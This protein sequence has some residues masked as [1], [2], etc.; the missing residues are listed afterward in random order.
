V[1]LIVC[2][3]PKIDIAIPRYEIPIARSPKERTLIQPIDYTV[4][5]EDFV[6]FAEYFNGLV[7]ACVAAQARVCLLS[8]S[9]HPITPLS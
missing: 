4:V 7:S 3:H 8:F 9:L 5:I 2:P 1:N 6:H